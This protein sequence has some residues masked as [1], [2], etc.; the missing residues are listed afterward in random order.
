M[1]FVFPENNEEEF[2][3][4]AEK[5][6]IKELVFVYTDKN[7]VKKINNHKTALLVNPKQGVKTK[8]VDYIMIKSGE[9]DRYALEKVK[10]DFMFGFEFWSE[11]DHMHQRASG[12]NDVFCKLAA[13]NK[14]KILFPFS[15]FLELPFYRKP[16]I[17]G[18]L[19]QNKKL[20]RKYNVN[21]EI[22][23]LAKKPYQLRKKM[24]LDSLFN[25]L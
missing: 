15:D 17:L 9:N 12:L 3:K 2:I 13:K 8:I 24:D 21:I 10:P 11:R 25:I 1:D 23:S 7:K 20:C 18:R 6:S 4:I 5:L 22:V 14:I 19:M 16:L